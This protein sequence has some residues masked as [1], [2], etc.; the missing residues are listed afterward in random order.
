MF[1]PTR[2]IAYPANRH[3]VNA[4]VAEQLRR[5]LAPHARVTRVESNEVL[6]EHGVV[7][8]AVLEGGTG[9]VSGPEAPPDSDWMFARIAA[10]GGQLCASKPHLLYALF[11]KLRD[12]W[13]IQDTEALAEGR[14][15]RP[16]FLRRHGARRAPDRPL[17]LPQ[18]TPH[19]RR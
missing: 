13:A 14:L 10:G 8:V 6:A 5:V 15:L 7:R 3:P 1:T 18:A 4:T 16:T 9:F 11:A 12:E 17:R 2:I 19:G